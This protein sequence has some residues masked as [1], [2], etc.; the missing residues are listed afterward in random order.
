MLD[1]ASVELDEGPAVLEEAS[2]ELDDGAAVLEEASVELEGGVAE[3]EDEEP[4][5]NSMELD[6]ELLG[7]ELLDD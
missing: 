5:V 1:D 6:D 2:V 7:D 4:S 3:L